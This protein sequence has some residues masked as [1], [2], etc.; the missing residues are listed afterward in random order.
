MR[1]CR[2]RV[3]LRKC[4]SAKGGMDW[5]YSWM[6]LTTPEIMKMIRSGTF[7]LDFRPPDPSRF[8]LA[9]LEHAYL[10][11]CLYLGYVPLFSEAEQIRR[12]LSPPVTRHGGSR[13]PQA[14]TPSGSPCTDRTCRR[15]VRRWLSWRRA[16]T[17]P[18]KGRST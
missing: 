1:T 6:S 4:S 2:D 16:P 13:H 15:R 7:W 9:A 5:P 11:A 17:I 8:K 14:R 3:R 12:N 18:T 10:A